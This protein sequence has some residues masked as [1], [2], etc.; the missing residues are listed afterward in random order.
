M[1]KPFKNPKIRKSPKKPTVAKSALQ[2][3][4]R[5]LRERTEPLK[6]IHKVIDEIVQ[7]ARKVEVD[8]MEWAKVCK[9]RIEARAT[10]KGGA[11]KKE[12]A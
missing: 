8:A 1:R 10:A 9:T 2:D 5:Q 6:A 4:E 12:A 11:K 3:N 7:L